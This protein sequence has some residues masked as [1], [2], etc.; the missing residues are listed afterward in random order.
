MVKS[1]IFFYCNILIILFYNAIYSQQTVTEGSLLRINFYQSTVDTN[2]RVEHWESITTS[3]GKTQEAFENIFTFNKTRYFIKRITTDEYNTSIG[4]PSSFQM[5]LINSSTSN[6][7]SL[8]GGRYPEC[9][10]GTYLSGAANILNVEK[11]LILTNCISHAG[12]YLSSDSLY[13]LNNGS[14]SLTPIHIVGRIHNDY[15]LAATTTDDYGYSYYL[16][17]FDSQNNLVVKNK[18]TFPDVESPFFAA[19]EKC[20]SLNDSLS[21]IS[22]E[23]SPSLFIEKLKDSSFVKVDVLSFNSWQSFWT[24]K[25]G[26]LYFIDDQNL[27]RRHFNS[28]NLSF[29]QKEIILSLGSSLGTDTQENFLTFTE[30]DSIN[31]YS[32]QQNQ[33]INKINYPPRNQYFNM[34][35]DSPYVYIHVVD[36]ITG[37][38]Q[39]TSI[40]NQFILEQNFP[41][42]F[43]PTTTIQFSIPS[44]SQGE[45]Q[46]VRLVTLKVY[47]VLG[48]EI[49]TLVNE[50]K[51]PGNYQVTFDGS[52]LPSGVYF[53]RLEA[54][55]FSQT[56][57]F[58]LMK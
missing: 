33:I 50:Q 31:I 44:P 54:G 22:F 58:V 35:V 2:D 7:F 1:K 6:E 18:V 56:K 47:D 30:N 4:P 14:T 32:F 10:T 42:P 9:G 41:N 26:Y 13:S 40:P 28:N 20:Y 27:A 39:S 55:S 45:G 24:V 12:Y 46:R 25:N 36:K 34:L 52:E 51:S 21:I 5:R 23:W 43:N 11:G 19:P 48:Q 49:S 8:F 15:L 3:S 17:N 53:Y 16:I 57:K 38:N 37:V 29:G